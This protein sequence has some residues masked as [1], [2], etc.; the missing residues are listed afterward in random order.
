MALTR[1]PSLAIH[2]I[3]VSSIDAS[4]TLP[5]LVR[6][7]PFGS[8]F[9]TPLWWRAMTC[10]NRLNAGDPDEPAVVSVRYQTKSP[11]YFSSLF[12]RT[13]ICLVCPLGCWI[14]VR[15][16][17]GSPLPGSPLSGS[18]PQSDRFRPPES[19]TGATAT[20]EYSSLSLV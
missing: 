14:M 13:Q 17:P 15:Y 20:I 18:H 7:L 1:A 16:S 9:G 12:S 11:T 8:F 3:N 10:Q 4:Q 6:M 2:S 19:D 5:S